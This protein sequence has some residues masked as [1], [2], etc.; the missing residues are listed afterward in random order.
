MDI[1]PCIPADDSKRQ[2]IRESMIIAGEYDYSIVEQASQLTIDIT[3]NRHPQYKTICSDWEISNPAG[4][5]LWFESRMS[6]SQIFMEARAQVD[7]LPAF[8]IKTPLQMVIQLLKRHRDTMFKDDPDVKPISII[9]TTLAARTYRG[10]SELFVVLQSILANLRVFADSKNMSIPN[11]VDPGE[12]FADRWTMPQ[13]KHLNLRE[14]FSNWVIQVQND[15]NLITGSE[16]TKVIVEQSSRKFSVDMNE[17][18]L[19]S[20]LGLP[21]IAAAMIAPKIHAIS[22]PAKPWTMEIP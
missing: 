4:Y 17:T 7:D 13:Y 21:L 10:E 8:E 19:K 16:N 1:V 3:D 11:P 5:A 18:D 6:Q 20:E 2:S 9:I 14:N 15:F 22:K 12:N